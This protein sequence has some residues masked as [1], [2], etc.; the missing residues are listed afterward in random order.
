[1]TETSESTAADT[2]SDS[3]DL[4]AE[5]PGIK[6]AYEFVLPSYTMMINRFEAADSRLT[7]LLTLSSTLT[8]A[9][10]TILK[11]AGPE[12]TFHF[13]SYWFLAGMVLVGLSVSVGVIARVFGR[14]SLPDPMVHYKNSL[15]KDEWA[16]KKDAIYRAGEAFEQNAKVVRL[17]AGVAK[18]LLACL[19]AEI[20]CLVVWLVGYA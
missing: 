15:H 5:Y 18:G 17:K 7:W 4:A 6:F 8:L 19:L 1:M 14:L 13:E 2:A 16:F 11:A 9:V 3:A 12:R 10:P 20:A